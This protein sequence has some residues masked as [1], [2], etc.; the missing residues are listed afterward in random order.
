V[1]KTELLTHAAI[2]ALVLV[3]YTLLTALNHDAT[4]LLGV[5]V[6]QG[7]TVGATQAIASKV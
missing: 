6:G 2:A 7:V 3:C 1:T 4:L 5:L